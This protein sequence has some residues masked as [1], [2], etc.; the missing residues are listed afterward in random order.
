MT[1]SS[2][3]FP[4]IA[5]QGQGQGQG[6]AHLGRGELLFTQRGVCYMAHNFSTD[7]HA[8]YEERH[9]SGVAGTLTS[10]FQAASVALESGDHSAWHDYGREWLEARLAR[11]NLNEAQIPGAN[12]RQGRQFI[13]ELGR[14][15]RYKNQVT[16]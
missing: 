15:M 4:V 13:H 5:P 1:L 11:S 8:Q 3:A 2:E 16:G 7:S 14:A 6:L 10:G 9:A 12:F